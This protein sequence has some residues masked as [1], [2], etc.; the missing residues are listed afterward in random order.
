MSDAAAG[1][2][3]ETNHDS[4]AETVVERC[5]AA[6][7]HLNGPPILPTDSILNPSGL[8]GCCSCMLNLPAVANRHVDTCCVQSCL[9]S[10][11]RSLGLPANLFLPTITTFL[12]STECD[13]LSFQSPCF[14]LSLQVQ[15]LIRNSILHPFVRR[16]F[17]IS[18]RWTKLFRRF[19]I[20]G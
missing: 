14:V 15:L 13:C 12:G 7:Q 9:P 19:S 1:T 8:A 18:I 4:A 16:N 11:F 2:K 3:I 5:V 10:V 20:S 6:C 17:Q